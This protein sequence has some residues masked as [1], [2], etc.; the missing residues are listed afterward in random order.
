MRITQGITPPSQP[1][2]SLLKTVWIPLGSLLVAVLGFIGR[3]VPLWT[4]G[5]IVG[6]IIFVVLA[7]LIPYLTGLGRWMRKRMMGRSLAAKF[8]PQLEQATTVLLPNLETSR[9]DTVYYVWTSI[10]SWGEAAQLVRPD[11]AHLQTLYAWLRSIDAR[12]RIKKR[13]GFSKIADELSRMI[14]QYQR[15]C[16]EAYRQLDALASAGNLP[17]QKLRNLKQEWNHIRD[18]H[19]QTLKAWEDTAKAINATAGDHI[20][21]DYYQLLKTIE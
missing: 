18:K 13:R 15:F 16:E 8:Y 6:Y 19:N 4:V 21:Q 5:V 7:V 2:E 14:L 12:L 1:K 20:C 17:S 9:G 3:D 11:H 10:G